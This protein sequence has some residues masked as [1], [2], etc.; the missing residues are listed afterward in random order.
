MMISLISTSACCISS[1]FRPRRNGHPG[2]LGRKHPRNRGAYSGTTAG[3][4]NHFSFDTFAHGN[5]SSIVL[6]QEARQRSSPCVRASSR[7]TLR[8]FNIHGRARQS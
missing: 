5:T 4:E 6:I 2:T 1:R 8:M 3:D 7:N